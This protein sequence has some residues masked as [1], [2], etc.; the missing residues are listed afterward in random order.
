MAETLSI[1][2]NAGFAHGDP[3]LDNVMVETHSNDTIKIKLIDYCQIHHS[4]FKYCQKLNCFNAALHDRFKEDLSNSGK[5]GKGFR[6]ALK[7]MDADLEID[8]CAIFDATY[9]SFRKE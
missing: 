6:T 2:H 9:N 8:L 1:W 5:L 7:K 4:D 3:H